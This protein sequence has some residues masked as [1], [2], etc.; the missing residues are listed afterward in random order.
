MDMKKIILGLAFGLLL[1]GCDHC[2]Q[3]PS[4]NSDDVSNLYDRTNSS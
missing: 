3:N 1:A 4:T 2:A